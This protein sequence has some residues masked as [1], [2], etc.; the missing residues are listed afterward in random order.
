LTKNDFK[1]MKIIGQFNLGFMLA[2]TSDGNLWILDQHACDEKYNFERLCRETVIHEQRLIA[3]LPLEL[4]PTEE[5]CVLDHMDIFEKNGFHFLYDPKR[6]VRHRL[7]LTALPHSGARDGRKAVQF[8]KEDVIA[9]C[10]ILGASDDDCKS[11]SG[12]TG[13][14]GNGM[15]GNNAVKRH[16]VRS[17]PSANGDE[18]DKII[19]RLPKAIAMFAS[20]ACRGSI[21]IGRALSEIEMNRIVKRLADIEHPWNCP[22]G[23][24][25]MRHVGDLKSILEQD[26]RAAAE[27]VAGPTITV[28]SQEE[29]SNI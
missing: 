11:F 26:E 17:L 28:L 23:R 6:P 19:A 12:G 24:P 1:N 4:S 29:Q 22:H 2:I 21:M 8:G 27:H 13:V 10:E 20:R 7:S 3:P 5:T 18:A 15:F 16:A 25:T 14:D 9:L